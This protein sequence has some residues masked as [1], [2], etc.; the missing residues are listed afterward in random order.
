MGQRFIAETS[1][2][3]LIA[4]DADALAKTMGHLTASDDAVVLV[5]EN[6]GKIVG[7]LGAHVFMHPLSG[8]RIAAELFWWV[9]PEHR[10]AGLTLLRNAEQWAFEKD[11]TAMQMV[12]PN[13]RIGLVYQALGY[14][15][16][17]EH[18]QRT[19]K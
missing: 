6:G 17:E 9:E 11:A 19:L 1:Y 7:M 13:E 3:S 4:S 18:Y 2:H 15:K 8:D 16:I 14:D 10:G 5:L 12:A